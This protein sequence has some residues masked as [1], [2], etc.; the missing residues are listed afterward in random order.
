MAPG[1]IR[2]D[3]GGPNATFSI[4]ETIPELVDMLAQ[5]GAPGLRFIDRHG[6]NVLW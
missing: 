6:A 3:M 1:W 5:Q 2:T 4:D